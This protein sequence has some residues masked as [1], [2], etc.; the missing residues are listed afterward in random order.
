MTSYSRVHPGNNGFLPKA[1]WH[2]RAKSGSAAQSTAHLADFWS[3]QG[4]MVEW[5][6]AFDPLQ[7]IITDQRWSLALLYADL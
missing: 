7:M 2:S 4:P 3:M 1:F 5:S 6:L